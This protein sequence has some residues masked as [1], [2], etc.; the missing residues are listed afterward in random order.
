MHYRELLRE[1]TSRTLY[2]GT[3]RRL[4]P[5]IMAIGLVP[6]IGEFTRHAY[7]E[8]ETAGID[9]PPLVFAA[10]RTGLG[11]CVSAI[12]GAIGQAGIATRDGAALIRYGAI[13]VLKHAAE[14]FAHRPEFDEN[15]WGEHPD[16]VEPGDYYRE[17]GITPDFAIT[18]KRLRGFLRRNSIDL[19]DWD[20][21][22]DRKLAQTELVARRLRANPTS[23]R[24]AV[25]TTV[26]ALDDQ[27]LRR[28]LP[29]PGQPR[30]K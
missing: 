8:Y 26:R 11:S 18:G 9:L 13:V 12:L 10:D 7:A 22:W 28:L 3:L 29:A 20:P 14:E 19:D 23:R 16:T 30:G 5:A 6:D 1:N 25:A 2:H 17:Y 21:A 24:G 4:V 27:A 15:Y